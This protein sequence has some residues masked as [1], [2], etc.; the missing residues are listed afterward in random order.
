MA[1]NVGEAGPVHMMSLDGL[2]LESMLMAV[3]TNRVNLMDQQL[4]DQ[5]EVVQARNNRISELNTNM[6]GMN[7]AVAAIGGS[8]ATDPLND[9]NTAAFLAAAPRG[10]VDQ[11]A[12]AANEKEIE[13]ATAMVADQQ[14]AQGYK[15]V[16]I[17]V[18]EERVKSLTEKA[19]TATGTDDKA[20][21]DQAVLDETTKL[22]GYRKD[23]SE[24]S[25]ALDGAQ[26]KLKAVNEQ[27]ADLKLGSIDPDASAAD[28]RAKAEAYIKSL[29]SEID[30]LGNSQ[31]MDMLRLQSLSNKRNE[32]FEIMTN[33]M[34]KLADSRS[35]IIQKF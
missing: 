25:T 22:D 33:F 18:S 15:R 17:G 19:N 10:P 26:A 13:T 4:K 6:N 34:K 1:T 28:N 2:D 30:A 23:M 3:Q 29:S 16:D 14:T 20:R 7:A 32:A 27:S 11:A 9:E 24:I 12:V 35:G 31:Q 8:A 21:A 5:M